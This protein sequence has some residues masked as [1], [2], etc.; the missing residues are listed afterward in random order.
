MPEATVSSKGWVVI[1]VDMRRKYGLQPG[2]KV[3]VVDYGGVISLVPVV[4]DPVSTTAGIL[5]GGKSL[6][7]A[8]VREHEEEV[9]RESR[10]RR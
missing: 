2:T 10:A 4:E 5:R 1:P 3:R 9:K 6:T 8:I 7:A